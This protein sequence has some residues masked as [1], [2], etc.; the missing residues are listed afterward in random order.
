VVEGVLDVLDR[1]PHLA[2]QPGVA[3]AQRVDRAPGREIGLGGRRVISRVTWRGLSA[4]L[5]KRPGKTGRSGR[6]ETLQ[7]RAYARVRSRRKSRR[8]GRSAR[9][10]LLPG[11]ALQAKLAAGVLRNRASSGP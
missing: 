3:V 10:S 6:V 11:P 9:F 4:S 8:K 1:R 7:R 2:E 5:Q